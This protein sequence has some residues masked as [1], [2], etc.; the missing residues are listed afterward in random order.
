MNTAAVA[1]VP[2]LGSAEGVTAIDVGRKVAATR[3]KADPA[4]VQ[5]LRM[6]TVTCSSS[7][8]TRRCYGRNIMA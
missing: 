1:I 5:D 8:W 2:G 3:A 6:V 7:A 4:G